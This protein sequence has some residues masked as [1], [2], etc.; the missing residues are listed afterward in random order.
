MGW[1]V[2]AMPVPI[3]PRER[4]GTHCHY[5]LQRENIRHKTSV[6]TESNPL[7]VALIQV[8]RVLS[9]LMIGVACNH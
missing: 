6:N 4:G 1:V 7:E 3:Y 5:V 8:L 2:N 9:I